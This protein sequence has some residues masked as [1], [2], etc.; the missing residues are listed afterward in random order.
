MTTTSGRREVLLDSHV[1]LWVALENNRLSAAAVAAMEAADHLLVS[2]ATLYEL[3]SKRR[4][5]GKRAEGI[6]SKLPPDLIGFLTRHGCDLIP[7]TPEAAW[8]AANLPMRHGDPWDRILVAQ[9]QLLEVPLISS[10]RVL[11]RQAEDV[12]LIW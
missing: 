3:D 7:I 11:R 6:L 5:G 2:A 12:T 1:A 8:R 9:A 10:D 4:L